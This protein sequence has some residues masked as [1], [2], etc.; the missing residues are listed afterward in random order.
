MRIRKFPAII[1][2]F[3]LSL[4]CFSQQKLQNSLPNNAFAADSILNIIKTLASKELRGRLPGDTGFNTAAHYVATIMQ[5]IGLI[6]FSEGLY[7]QYFNTEANIFKPNI[8][9]S[10]KVGNGAITELIIGRDYAFRG[11]TGSGN[12]K[13]AEI[14]F[15]GYGISDSVNHY[16]DYKNI[17]VKNKAVLIF[18]SNPGFK[19][20][21]ILKNYSIRE[22]AAMA[23][24]N[25]ASAVIFV[26]TPNVSKPQKPIGSVMHGDG[27]YI[28][29]LPLLQID[30][31]IAEKLFYES[32]FTLSQLQQIIDS[33]EI[34]KSINLKA[35]INIQVE[36]QY[37]SM[38]KTMNVVGFLP[39]S[40]SLLKNEYIVLGAHL[41]HVGWQGN[42]FYPGANDNASG[43]AVVLSIARALHVLKP[44]H[45]RSI[46]FALF[47]CEEQG[48]QGATHFVNSFSQP[49]HVIKAM[50]NFDCVGHG[51][52]I[53][54]GCGKS[55]PALWNKIYGID[56]ASTKMMTKHTWQGGGADAQPFFEKGVATAYF[57]SRYSYTHLHLPS[58][59]LETLNPKLLEAMVEL[60]YR[61]LLEV[62][63]E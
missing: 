25:G 43:V 9:V 31:P 60:G 11:F 61:S 16:N 8:H 57:V 52:S 39:G 37:N 59:T 30:I 22:K 2:L 7:F 53:Q 44:L 15:C 4:H 24:Q 18:K 63:N 33:S 54:I 46:I 55:F 5:G 38:A 17:D 42:V 58:D 28:K 20:K 26:S 56:S 13:N 1:L 41:D 32:G 49:Q 10:T 19:T 40:D 12:I 14:I 35:N 34:P 47:A 45:K 51:D 48:L 62:C 3:V 27:T 50:Y 36:T 21:K 6:P 29:D 23:F